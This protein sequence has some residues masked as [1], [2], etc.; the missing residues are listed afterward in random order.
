MHS[1]PVSSSRH[2]GG[3]DVYHI[4]VVDDFLDNLWLLKIV[5]ETEGYQVSTARDGELALSLI[6]ASPPDLV[7]LDVLMPGISGYEVTRQIRQC[8][9]L[10][11]LPVILF[12]GCTDKRDREEALESGA[13]DFIS[14]PIDVAELLRKVRI[15]CG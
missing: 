13:N 10:K 7:L 1:R 11:Y 14:K 8:S 15:L 4:L 5:L 2:S 6:Q 3:N 9:T 12:T